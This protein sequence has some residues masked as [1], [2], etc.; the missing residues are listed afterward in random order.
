[1]KKIAYL[2]FATVLFSCSSDENSA[3]ATTQN[4]FTFKGIFYETQTLYIID[5]NTSDTTPSDISFSFINKT[6]EQMI[7]TGNLS[8][9]NLFYFDFNAIKAE[10]ITYTGIQD[11]S[12]SINGTRVSG[13]IFEG[14]VILSDNETSLEASA[15]SVTIH[16]ITPN[17]VDLSFSFTRTDGEVVTGKYVGNY[18]TIAQL[19]AGPMVPVP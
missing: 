4:G 7:N 19:P 2:L 3:T 16:S 18:L 11:Y 6:R 17:S 5:E 10:A 1:M 8:D 14:N 12:C 13:E 9:L 15:I